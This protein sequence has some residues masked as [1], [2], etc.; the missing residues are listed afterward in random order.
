MER[1]IKSVANVTRKDGTEFLKIAAELKIKS[2]V[3]QYNFDDIPE[4][5]IKV[6]KG[7]IDGTA[8]VSFEKRV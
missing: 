6:S 7:E 2:R 5:L 8:V 3:E 1:S 4:A